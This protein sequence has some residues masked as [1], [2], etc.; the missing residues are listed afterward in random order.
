MDEDE[1]NRVHL[2]TG[3][4]R[5]E[6]HQALFTHTTAQLS[7]DFRGEST[8]FSHPD[9]TFPGEDCLLQ[10]AQIGTSQRICE[11]LVSERA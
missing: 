11:L 5:R 4:S 3:I 1:K 8:I 2:E 7:T 6:F 9:D 10:K